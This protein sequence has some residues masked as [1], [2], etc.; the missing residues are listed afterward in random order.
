MTPFL[1]DVGQKLKFGDINF[2]L[3]PFMDLDFEA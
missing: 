3:D 2:Q 1:V